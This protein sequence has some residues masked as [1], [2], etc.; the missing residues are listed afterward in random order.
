MQESDSVSVTDSGSVTGS[1]F[2]C[3]LL[4]HKNNNHGDGWT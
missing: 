4:L 3:K 1:G 2:S